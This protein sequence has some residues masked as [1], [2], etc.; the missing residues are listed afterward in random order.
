MKTTYIFLFIFF[1]INE[2]GNAFPNVCTVV[3]THSFRRCLDLQ[4]TTAICGWGPWTRPCAR[5]TYYVPQYFIEVVSNPKDSFFTEV[6]GAAIQLNT[7]SEVTP[8]GAEDDNGAYSFH[9]HTITVPFIS[10]PF[11]AMPCGGT[12]IDNFC[13]GAMSEHLGSNWK[14][15]AADLS[16]PLFLAWSASPKTCLIKGA[17][18]SISG[19]T[20]ATSYPYLGMCSFDRSFLKKYPP[21][22]QPVCSGWG[23][24][25]PRYGTVTNADQ[26]TASLVVA[27]RIRSLGSEVFQSVDTDFSEKWQMLYPQASTCFNEG[28][29]IGILRFKGV[30]EL[31]RIWSGKMKNYLYV[32]WKKVSCKK[33]LFQIPPTYAAV[34][35]MSA[36]C[37]GL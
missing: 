18:M 8:F 6:P 27:S 19:E 2:I 33:E 3:K 26:T 21:S 15:G 12:Q 24:M 28:Q 34:E 30:N 29:N 1:T 5:F 4:I 35:A 14:T 9:V 31:G 16:Q 25:F 7:T 36:V 37:R 17:A 23:I 11:N 10:I 22:Y 32:V 13:F 20:R